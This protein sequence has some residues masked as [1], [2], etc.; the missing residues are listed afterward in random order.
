[1]TARIPSAVGISI[2]TVAVL[3]TNADSTQVTAPKARTMRSVDAPTPGSPRTKNATRCA[4]PCLSMAWARMKAPMNVNTVVE[5]NGASTSSEGATPSRMIALTPIRPAM[6]IGTG[7]QIHS[8]MTP[9]STAASVC[10]SPSRPR[11]SSPNTTATAGARNQPT[12]RRPRS[13]R[14]SA[15][16]SRCSERLR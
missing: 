14:S 9:S 3:E 8:T 1:M 2:A 13:K 11:G 10:W 16:D 4:T 7:S 5:P 15:G 12:V 6:G